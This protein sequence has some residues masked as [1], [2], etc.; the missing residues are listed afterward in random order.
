M[1]EP[2]SPAGPPGGAL[3][4]RRLGLVLF[5]L[6]LLLVFWLAISNVFLGLALV[7]APWTA[8]LRD[9]LRPGARPLLAALAAYVVL[10]VASVIASTDPATSVR[11]LSEIFALGTLALALALIRGADEARLLVDGV[12]LVA[13][14]IAGYGLF[15]FLIGYGDLDNRIRGPLSHY[16]TFSG[17]L[18]IA[19]LLLFARLAHAHGWR[20]PWNWATAAVLNVA[21]LGSLT[22]SAWVALAVALA[23]LVVLRAPRLLLLA[24][25]AALVFLLLAPVPLL[26]RM[27]S[28]VDLTDES[29]YDRICMV[30]AGLTMIAERP[31]FGIGPDLVKS[32]YPIYRHPTAPRY[33]VPHLHNSFLQLAAE[34]GL[35]ALAAYLALM[36]AAARWA[37]ARLRAEG[38]MAGA[39]ADLHLG[40][41][42]ALVGF[43]LAGL[44]ENN[45]GDSEV[46]RMALFVLALPYVSAT[47]GDEPGTL[48]S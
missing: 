5:A 32:R 4:G 47:P 8:R 28:I 10:L 3:R 44:F 39:N 27:R 24:P 18:L 29:N 12:I 16:M 19:D 25:I 40:T 45:W 34:R 2:G 15:Q 7:A 6:H 35:P 30:R 9:V 11:A 37:L 1:P 48:A 33:T 42:L 20:N 17:V 22:R 21:L 41:F 14:G 46:Q 36:L 31:A 43:N 23:I 38:G 26:S 13:V